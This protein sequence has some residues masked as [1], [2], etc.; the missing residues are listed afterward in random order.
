[1]DHTRHI[2]LYDLSNVSATIIGAGGIGATTEIAL[3]K[4]GLFMLHIIDADTVGTENMATQL[5][6][7]QDVGS[8]KPIAIRN[9]IAEYADCEVTTSTEY[10]TE[11]TALMDH[12]IISAV[13]NINTRKAIWSSLKKG[14]SK[15]RFYLDARMS[16]EEFHL[17]MVDF[18]APETIE[19]YDLMLSQESEENVP[20]EPCTSHATIFCAFAAAAH[21]CNAVK[22]LAMGEKCP[23]VLIH[24]LKNFIFLVA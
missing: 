12:F 22:K 19:K 24:N 13:D 11:K 21:I 16:A 7:F 17:Y 2:D 9:A 6:R 8:P 4:M 10:V 14:I 15:C 20:E 23:T 18:Q 3:A 5:H 1:M